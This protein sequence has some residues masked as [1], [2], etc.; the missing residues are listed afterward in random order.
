M[1]KWNGLMKILGLSGKIVDVSPNNELQV[2][3]GGGEVDVH[4]QS[5]T[6]QKFQFFA[7][8]EIKTD[9]TLTADVAIGDDVI[10]VSGSHGF[11]SAT[12]GEKIA[13][14]DGEFYLQSSIKSVSSNA[15]TIFSPSVIPFTMANS[16]VI[17]GNAEMAFDN[18]AG[19]EYVW[20]PRGATIPIDISKV[21]ITF[22][23]GAAVP[24]MGKFGG[25]DPSLIPN[26]MYFRKVN[27][28]SVD[29]G[30]YGKN[31]D[32]Q[33][34]GA[35]VSFTDKAPAGTNGV[36]IVFDLHEIF[37]G[38][39]ERF[40]PATDHF[41]CKAADDYNIAGIASMTMSIIGSYTSGELE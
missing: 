4:I 17:R 3:V 22:E 38:N 9:I 5:Q 10:N 1:S 27:G 28:N 15:I 34:L 8:R 31:R 21:I 35:S 14:F 29:L 7:M 33:N 36:D 40:F 25:A 39:I 23:C 18:S 26:K 11:L 12:V 6:G 13:I 41:L 37:D 16:V 19:V 20:K 32:F 2:I 30:T 24:D